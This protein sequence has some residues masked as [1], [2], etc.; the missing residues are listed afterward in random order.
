MTARQRT[1]MNKKAGFTLLEMLAVLA[2]IA[3][4]A[5]LSTHLLRPPS[6]RLRAEAAARALCAAARA[7]RMRA[8]ATNAQTTLT[9][10]LARKT[11]SSPV[12]AET[13]LPNDARIA[14]SVASRQGASPSNAGIV[15][16]PGGGSTG[17]DISIELSGSRATVEVNWLT[18]ETRC[19]LT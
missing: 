12:V 7:T 10:D 14:V 5:S 1:I 2:I 3:L 4:V 15:F 8:I 19:G 16:F 9:L 6:P 18:G 13:A 17:A 11:F